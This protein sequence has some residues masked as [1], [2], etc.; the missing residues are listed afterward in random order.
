LLVDTALYQ[1]GATLTSA[2]ISGSWVAAAPPPPPSGEAVVWTTVV[3]VSVSGNSLTKSAA[4]GWGN[5]GAVSTKTLG[6]GDGSV[7][8]TASEKTTDRMFGLGKGDSNQHWDDIDFGF[9]LGGNGTLRV[10]EAGVLRG[11]FSSYATGDK[12]QVVVESG[13]VRY[14]R[15]GA[16]FYTSTVTPTYPLLVD[17]ALYQ[18]GATLTS[19][20]VSGNWQ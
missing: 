16:V 5:A 2:T 20:I 7:E 15:N 14:K 19:A 17:T 8:V 3:G 1:Q 4:T 13:V 10:Y 9:Y 6:S 18:Q 11:I 12:L